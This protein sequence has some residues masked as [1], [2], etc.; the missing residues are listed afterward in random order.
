MLEKVI[1]YFELYH[2]LLK[3]NGGVSE[4]VSVAVAEVMRELLYVADPN[5]RYFPNEPL[6][7][8]F[9]HNSD[10]FLVNHMFS[11]HSKLDLCIK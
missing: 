9:V 1:A 10:V 11:F 6:L 2:S 7:F 4:R 8:K 5:R 3:E